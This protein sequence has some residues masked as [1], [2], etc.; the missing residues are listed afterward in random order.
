VG[1]VLDPSKLS[2]SGERCLKR[3]NELY[4]L[5]L[6]PS[7]FAVAVMAPVEV[8]ASVMIARLV[9]RSAVSNTRFGAALIDNVGEGFQETWRMRT[10]WLDDGFEI[11]I[12]G[13]SPHQDLELVVDARNAFVHGDGQLTDRQTR[14]PAKLRQLRAG[15]EKTLKIN[16]RGV[17][18]RPTAQTPLL[19]AETVRRFVVDYDEQILRR[20]PH[21]RV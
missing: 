1:S 21:A 18:M 11:E 15:L 14:E 9:S 2:D 3:V 17:I 20:Y 8:H 12:A 5:A 6:P 13:K 16:C 4:E 10:R 7:Q 19:V